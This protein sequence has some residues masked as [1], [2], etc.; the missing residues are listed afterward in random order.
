[1]LNRHV[2]S[3][4]L[5]L[6]IPGLQFLNSFPDVLISFQASR[7]ALVQAMPGFDVG[8]SRTAAGR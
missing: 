6:D 1:L 7:I 3:R 2:H 4:L 5:R 8:I